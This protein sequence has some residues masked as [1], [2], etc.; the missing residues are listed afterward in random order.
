[1]GAFCFSFS[2]WKSSLISKRNCFLKLRF[3]IG[4]DDERFW[5]TWSRP[6]PLPVP[7]SPIPFLL[8]SYFGIRESTLS[9]VL[10]PRPSHPPASFSFPSPCSPLL[11]E[12]LSSHWVCQN[13]MKSACFDNNHFFLPVFSSLWHF[14][15]KTKIPFP[16][17]FSALFMTWP[18][19][20][21]MKKVLWMLYQEFRNK[22]W[23]HL[24]NIL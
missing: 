2:V 23:C 15:L 13:P 18:I 20:S 1:M 9:T 17:V 4:K 12:F 7:F 8:S 21:W 6:V 14:A 22:Q 5:Q 10:P 3:G 19:E 16:W 11:D 24:G